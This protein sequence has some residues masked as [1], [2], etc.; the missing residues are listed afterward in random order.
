ML[1]NNTIEYETNLLK[2]ARDGDPQAA[3]EL[4][5]RYLK[6]SRA[7]QGLLRRAL[8]HPEDREEMLHEI[9]LQLISGGSSFQGK[10]S[11]STYIYRVARVTIFQ[12]YRRENTLKRGKIYRKILEDTDIPGDD[13][14]SP[15]YGF[16]RKQ[17]REIIRGLLSKLPEAYR[18]ALEL[19]VFQDKSYD[20]IAREL[21]LPINTVSTRI[22]KG[23]KIL[24][25]LMKER[26]FREDFDL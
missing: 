21:N 13:K 18:S 5:V 3:D 24:S 20:E 6:E 4:F 19:R 26:G 17:A 2:R 7:I 1:S 14:A 25:S 12:K 9:Y 11:L 16:S 23:K 10:S 22:H 15:E 8:S